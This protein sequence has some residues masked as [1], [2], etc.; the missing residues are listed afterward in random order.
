MQ[1]IRSTRKV[2]IGNEHEAVIKNF[3]NF[4]NG[5]RIAYNPDVLESM[6]A[7]NVEELK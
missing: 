7:E 4:G 3:P 6:I 2:S 1:E 5:V